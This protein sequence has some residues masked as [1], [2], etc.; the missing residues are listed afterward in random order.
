MSFSQYLKLCLSVLK[1]LKVIGTVV[2]GILILEFAR[3]V[4]S[5]KK[6]P[7]KTKVAKAPKKEKEGKAE[8]DKATEEKSTEAAAETESKE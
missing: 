7:P 5:Y 1:D 3:Y 8:G 6:K 4:T 2:V